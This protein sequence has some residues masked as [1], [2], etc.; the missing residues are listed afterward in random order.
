MA[1]GDIPAYAGVERFV[2]AF[3]KLVAQPRRSRSRVPV[4][5]LTE[6]AG[7]Q[8]GRRI[9]RGLRGRL[10]GRSEVLASHAYVPAQSPQSA[11]PPALELFEQIA[12]QLAESMPAGT[13]QLRLPGYRLLHAVVTATAIDGPVEHRHS[14][15]RNHC[16]AEHRRWSKAA[17]TLWW[18]GGRDQA[19]GGTLIETVWN[20]V[21]GPLFQSLPRWLF[22]IGAS[23]R[24][25]GRGRNRRWYAE[26]ARLQHGTPPK[27]FFR[28]ALDHVPGGEGSDP[29]R[30]DRVLMHALLADLDGAVRRRRANPWRRRR[31]TRFVLLFEEAGA[32]DSR[33]QRFLRELRSAV[34]DLRC[35]SVIAVAAGVRSLASRIPDIVAADLA[36]AGAE[37]TL[38]ERQGMRAGQPTGIVVPVREGPEDDEQAAYWIGRFPTLVAPSRRWGPRTEVAGAA[39]AALV[40]LA[41]AAGL[42]QGLPWVQAAKNSC[43]GATF[44]EDEGGECVGFAAGKARYAKGEKRIGAVLDQIN[45]QNKQV[46]EATAD[47]AAGRPHFR[48]V[49]Y[50]GPFSGGE[51]DEDPVRGGT[52]PELRGVALAQKYVNELALKG[53]GDRVP[54]YVLV[55]N[56]GHLFEHAPKVADS[57]IRRAERDSSIVGVVG[58]GQSRLATYRAIRKLD[59]AGI[60]MLGTSGTADA[61]LDQGLH[62]YQTAPVDSRAAQVMASFV[63]HAAMVPQPDGKPVR[64]ARVELVADRTDPYSNGLARSF[65]A[66]YT[67][68]GGSA[69]A[70]LVPSDGK[71]VSDALAGQSYATLGDLAERVC[72]AVGSGATPTAVVWTGRASQFVNFLEEYRKKSD[73]CPELSVLG[74]D[75]VTNALLTGS[76]PWSA[77]DR[78]SLYYISH[79][80]AAEVT[81]EGARSYLEA[82]GD[83]YGKDSMR[84]DPHPALAWDAL[85]YLS[86]AIDEAWVGTG[87]SDGRLDR[88]LVQAVLYQGLGGGGFNGATGRIDSRGVTGGRRLT[89]DKLVGVLRGSPKGAAETVLFCGA[90]TASDVRVKWGAGGYDC[91]AG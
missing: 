50:L 61:L 24:M 49:V 18:L 16:Y 81:G 46:S 42:L 51:G 17:D 72:A 20:L 37:L 65:Q 9:V 6:D 63:E 66:D 59:A 23:R 38:V 34:E 56:A 84:L 45:R 12:M 21:A 91:P 78:L 64:A 13:G 15:L 52:L 70:L 86:E 25:L 3:D 14:E 48:T 36:H 39:V 54:L 60:P 27:D 57:I 30:L 22:G 90:V 43:A 55:A 31:S 7:G 5:L 29:E 35:T 11:E 80:N 53:E 10:R 4:V 85:R 26:W 32:S 73:N 88:A 77:F 40:A 62:Y 87:R 44:L 83:T 2:E 8:A 58:F 71:P 67:A 74:G 19:S 76:S 69:E 1:T 33:V 82:Y 47:L 28:S 41:V 75:D 79:G 68:S 89:A